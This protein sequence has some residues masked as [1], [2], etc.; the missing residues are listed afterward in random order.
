MTVKLTNAL[1]CIEVSG[2]P[3][4]KAT[5]VTIEASTTGDW[6]PR[7]HN[8]I[9]SPLTAMQVAMLASQTT[10][11]VLVLANG[12]PTATYHDVRNLAVTDT[13][14]ALAASTA[15]QAA[16]KRSNARHD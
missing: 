7:V 6:F 13:R 5:R 15:A 1:H 10:N 14:A 4:Q 12:R 16:V 8:R 9:G 2:L 11:A 3:N